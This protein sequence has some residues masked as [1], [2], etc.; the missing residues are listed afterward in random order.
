MDDQ[1][2]THVLPAAIEPAGYTTRIGL[3]VLSTDEIGQRAF[4][5]VVPEGKASVV[6]TRAVYSD[7]D[8]FTVVGGFK[9]L[10]DA[11]PPPGRID[12]IAFSCTSGTVAMGKDRLLDAMAEGRPGLKY[13]SP[14]VAALA[15][16]EALKIH[17]I[18]LMTPY[19][20]AMHRQV[21]RFFSDEGVDIVA[22]ATF[23]LSTDAEI[24]ELSKAS[25]FSG[26]EELAAEPVDALFVSCTATP[27]VPY[28][29]EL[30]ERLGVT[31]ITSTQA[32]AWHAMRLGGFK[33]PVHG[34]GRLLK[35]Y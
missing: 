8:G 25:L 27:L 23:N 32:M 17:R 14:A 30:E 28:I 19:P 13:T 24:G 22:D 5:R 16:I 34:F 35:N 21:R 12:V 15:A 26:A 20:V 31:V 18:A 4:E 10:L 7:E 6:A 11:L 2:A 29:D 3:C 9:M 1:V 33:E